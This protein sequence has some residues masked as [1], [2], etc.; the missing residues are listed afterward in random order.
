MDA[1]KL[2]LKIFT[3]AKPG[4]EHVPAEAF[5][6]VFHD[7]IK[8]A[9]LPEL[10]VDVANYGHVPQGPGV[11]LIGHANDYAIDEGEG[12]QGLLFSRKRQGAAPAQRL[13]DTFRHA[14]HAATLL[15]QAPALAG[16]L[17]FDTTHVLFRI[18][19]R[20]AAPNTE[21]SFAAVRTELEAFC[22]RLFGPGAFTLARVGEPRQLF[23][24]AITAPASTP[25]SLATLLDRAGGPPT[26]A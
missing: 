12:R 11:V 3:A 10:L 6:P 22:A 14:L 24:V 16:K 2:Q 4:S 26:A 15:E 19:D 23:S 7:W 13:A 25:P 9:A 5:I 20:L 17:S 18:N 1:A 8:N 21:A